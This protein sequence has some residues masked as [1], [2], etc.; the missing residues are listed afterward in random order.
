MVT[1]DPQRPPMVPSDPQSVLRPASELSRL[2]K[3]RAGALPCSLVAQ[4][5]VSSK[6]SSSAGSSASNCGMSI[7][8]LLTISIQIA[9]QIAA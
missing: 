5:Y 2:G 3:A 1:C 6:R 9:G 4:R 8:P 7:A